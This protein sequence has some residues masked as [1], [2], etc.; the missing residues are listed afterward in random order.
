MHYLLILQD[1]RYGGKYGVRVQIVGELKAKARGQPRSFP[2]ASP[3]FP[4]YVISFI[5]NKNKKISIIYNHM[6]GKVVGGPKKR[7]E[8]G[9]EAAS[10][11]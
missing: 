10:P 3:R 4:P 6:R 7:E 8:A 5:C 11:C 9:I 2:V 1:L